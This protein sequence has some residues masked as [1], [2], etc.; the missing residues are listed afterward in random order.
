MLGPDRAARISITAIAFDGCRIAESYGDCF[1]E[2]TT[3]LVLGSFLLLNL[4]RL[5]RADN[6]ANAFGLLID[7]LCLVRAS[8]GLKRPDLRRC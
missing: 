7:H 2:Q 5:G 3:W 4:C 6:C 8:D 1:A